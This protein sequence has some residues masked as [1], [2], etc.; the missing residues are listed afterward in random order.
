MK[1][2]ISSLI[3]GVLVILL[4]SLFCFWAWNGFAR[5]FNLPIF[6]FWHWVCTFMAVRAL[7]EFKTINKGK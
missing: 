7:F 4:D 5:A 6:D 3:A 2:I 1:D